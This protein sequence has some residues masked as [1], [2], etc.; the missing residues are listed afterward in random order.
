[1]TVKLSKLIY[2]NKELRDKCWD[3]TN[4]DD[5]SITV[6]Q[7]KRFLALIYSNNDAELEKMCLQFGMKKKELSPNNPFRINY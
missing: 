7:Y 6:G 3:T 4:F 5:E 2:L 1:M